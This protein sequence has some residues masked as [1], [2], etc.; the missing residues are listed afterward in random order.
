MTTQPTSIDETIKEFES[1]FNDANRFLVYKFL[2][3]ETYANAVGDV[4]DFLLSK[5]TTLVEQ[6][7]QETVDYIEKHFMCEAPAGNIVQE[8]AELERVLE[9][10][11]TISSDKK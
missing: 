4:R 7:R 11:R 1:R 9:A 6:A 8:Y 3:H 2:P 5:L 10:A